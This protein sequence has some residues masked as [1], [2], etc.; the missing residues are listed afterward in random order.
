VF[1]NLA[2]SSCVYISCHDDDCGGGG[3]GCG[4]DGAGMNMEAMK[5]TYQYINTCNMLYGCAK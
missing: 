2:F 1:Q 5:P 3:H 4:D